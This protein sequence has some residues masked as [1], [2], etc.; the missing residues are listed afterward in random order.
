MANI[1][2]YGIGLNKEVMSLRDYHDMPASGNVHNDEV[3]AMAEKHR[4]AP[5]MSD[6]FLVCNLALNSNE[7]SFCRTHG[8]RCLVFR[9][10]HV[11]CT[12]EGLRI[13]CFTC[14]RLHH[15]L[16]GVMNI[17]LLR[18]GGLPGIGQCWRSSCLRRVW[19]FSSD[20]RKSV[21][22]FKAL[23]PIW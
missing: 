10:T 12:E 3:I 5:P 22:C 2:R 18:I 11:W 23:R 16:S 14:Q 8:S 7:N 6:C 4:I 1:K 20:Y 15:F 13:S 19:A 9:F 17:H 21:R